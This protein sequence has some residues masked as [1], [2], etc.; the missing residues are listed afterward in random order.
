MVEPGATGGWKYTMGFYPEHEERTFDWNY[1]PCNNGSAD[2]WTELTYLHKTR[3]VFPDG[4]KREMVPLGYSDVLNDGFYRVTHDGYVKSCGQSSTRTGG[5]VSYYSTDGS[6]LRLEYSYDYDTD[7]NNNTWTLYMPDGGKVTSGNGTTPQRAYDRNGNYVEYRT[8]TNYNSTGNLAFQVADQFERTVTLE[9]NGIGA[10]EDSIRVKGVDGEELL[11]KVK[12]KQTIV[13]K[14]Y[15]SCSDDYVC[16]EAHVESDLDALF[17]VVDTITPPAQMGSGKYTFSYNAPV[18]EVPIPPSDGWGEVSEIKLPSGATV[19]YEY[20]LDGEDGPESFDETKNILKNYPTLKTH[21]YDLEY[22]G[23]ISSTSD[24]WTYS[25]SNTGSSVTAP[26]GSVTTETFGNTEPSISTGYLDWNSGLS[27][28]SVGPNGTKTEN[29]WERNRPVAC[30]H[31]SLCSGTGQ[32]NPYVKTSFTSIKNAAGTYTLTAIKDFTYDKNGN[33][34][35]VKEYD[36][37]PYGDVPRTSGLPTGLPTGA[38]SYLKRITQTEF[39]NP[40]P[41][42]SS[43]TYTD[44]DS[45]HLASSPRLLRLTKASEVLNASSTP[46]SRSEIVYDY[47]DYGSSNTVAG[48]AVTTKVWDSIKGS[49]SNPLTSGN[50][51]T[52]S[53]TY[54]G[55]GMPTLTTDAND[56]DTQITYGNVTVGGSPVTGPYPTQTIVAH[57]TA[58][59]RTT[60]SV[61]DFYTGVVTSTTDEDNDVTNATEYDDLGRPTKSITA[62]GD[63]THESW[64]TTEYYDDDDERFVVVKSDLEVKGDGKK[65]A[66]Q[67]YDQLGRVRLSRTLEDASTQ[68]P[69]DPCR[70]TETSC[71]GIKVQTRYKFASGYTYQLTSNPYRADESDEETD[72]TMGWTLS[73][74]WTSGLRSEVQTFEGAGLPTEF[75]GS[76]TTST[77]IVRT[78]IDA[79]RTLVTDQAGKQRISKTNA[80]GQ[81]KDIWEVMSASDGSTSSVTFPGTSIAYGYATSYEYNPLNNLTTVTQGSQTRTFAYSSLSRLTSATNPE[82][83]TIAYEYDNN[84]NL[85]EKT[86]ARTIA[87]TYTYDVLNRVTARDYDDST[88]DVDYT[89]GTTAPKIGKLTKVE[90]SVSTTEYTGFDILGRVT[91]HKQ[92]TDGNDYTIGYTYNLS[93]AL[94]EETYPSGRVV[95][96][97]LDNNGELEIVQSKKNSSA[98]YWNYA[99]NFTY[100]PAGAVTAMQL[101]NGH[102]EST[103]FNSRLQPTQIALGTTGTSTLAYDLLKLN[104]TYDNGTASTNNGNVMSQTITVPGLT[105]PFIQSYTYD[106]LNRLKTATETNSSTQTWKQSFTFDRYGNRR[107]DESNTTIPES[108]SNP[109]VSNPTISTA[110]NRLTSSGWAYDSSG[111]TTGDPNGDTFIYDGENKQVEVKNSSNVTI[112]KYW[113]DGEGKRVKKEVPGTSEVTIFVYDAAGKSIAEYSTVVETTNAQVAYLTNDHLGSPRINTEANGTVTARH[114]YH[115]FGEEIYSTQRTTGLGYD[116]DTVRKQ[117]TGYE[118]DGETELDFAQ[119]RMYANKLGRFSVPDPENAGGRSNEPQTWN[120]YSYVVNNPLNL[121]DPTG[122]A[123]VRKGDAIY[124][125]DDNQWDNC[126]KSKSCKKKYKDYTYIPYGT[127]ITVPGDEEGELYA[128]AGQRVTL[129]RGRRVAPVSSGS[130]DDGPSAVNRMANGFENRAMWFWR[131]VIYG[132]GTVVTGVFGAPVTGAVTGVNYFALA[133]AAQIRQAGQFAFNRASG[134]IAESQATS[135]LALSGYN[136]VGTRVSANVPGNGRRVMDIVLDYNGQLFNIEVKSG[137]AVRNTTQIT[138]DAAMQ[139]GAKLVGRNAGELSGIT[140]DIKTIVYQM[141]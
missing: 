97:V 130:G 109:A 111:N 25:M 90:S 106:E 57:G 104:Y 11:T 71:A 30:T 141:P 135:E 99:E 33:V 110:N 39:Y 41:T 79:D 119:A 8:I 73:T 45:Y 76:N 140:R 68:V 103:T 28:V 115:S 86:D 49:Y 60:T 12:W 74:A 91:T 81:L 46:Q 78:D 128:Y 40:V 1:P 132:A 24:T 121:T 16:P 123:Y 136:I 52:T 94:I 2:P 84:G 88:P 10:G 126:Q 54:N 80:L 42:A 77:G 66:V 44:A 113:Y 93:G 122:L 56:V 15:Q 112:G 14:T 138:K 26:D 131:P 6:Y 23:S 27:L 117:F 9:F 55:Y 129:E 21:A 36:W 89:Y 32:I 82:S 18:Y 13:T 139:Q 35:E 120:A 17:S 85:T 105:H 92:T 5:P 48:N 3:M 37:V 53:A 125:V 51:I 95:K 67:Y 61:Y 72:P 65:V 50:W 20:T 29:L 96:N 116:L 134:V 101:G 64:T 107:F 124:W 70:T 137:G 133:R 63:T 59:A 69:D 47:T 7:P 34:T 100:N 98:G 31:G 83:G 75:G 87:T 118:R 102:W 4:S 43:T 114:D 108:F 127:E 62:V 19:S 58:L 38:S 22:D